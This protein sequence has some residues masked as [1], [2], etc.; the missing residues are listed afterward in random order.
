MRSYKIQLVNSLDSRA[1]NILKYVAV[2][3][4]QARVLCD[5]MITL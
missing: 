2:M 4:L 1:G 3:I 5:Q